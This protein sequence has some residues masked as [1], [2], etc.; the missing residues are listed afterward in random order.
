MLVDCA[1]AAATADAAQ[2]SRKVGLQ[3]VTF[4]LPADFN[5]RAWFL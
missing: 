1:V 3:P 4:R 2:V 5:Q